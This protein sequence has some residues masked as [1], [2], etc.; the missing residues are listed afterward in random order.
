MRIERFEDIE[1]WKDARGLAKM[2]YEI[3]SVEP[4]LPAAGRLRFFVSV[5]SI[6]KKDNIFFCYFCIRPKVT[7]RLD[8]T[9]LPRALPQHKQYKQ[10][11]VVLPTV[12]QSVCTPTPA[13]RFVRPARS[14]LHTASQLIVFSSAGEALSPASSS[15]AS[16]NKVF[17]TPL[18]NQTL[19]WSNQRVRLLNAQRST[20]NA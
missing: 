2:V 5:T 3:T 6:W 1:I 10:E 17:I 16:I 20:L 12:S 9:M 7:K 11:S 8:K 14:S 18:Q 19:P 13:R 15:F 4:W